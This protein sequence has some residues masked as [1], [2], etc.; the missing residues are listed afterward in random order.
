[1]GKNGMWILL[2][3]WISVL[4]IPRASLAAVT[5]AGNYGRD[6]LYLGD[7]FKQYSPSGH[8]FGIRVGLWFLGLGGEVGVDRVELSERFVTSNIPV[9]LS[10]RVMNWYGGVLI[11][12]FTP[13]SHLRGGITLEKMKGN[14]DGR[15]HGVDN[16]TSRIL[17]RVNGSEIGYYVG[18]GGNYAFGPWQVFTEGNMY[19]PRKMALFQWT[20]GVRYFL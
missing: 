15:P 1:M 5:V 9:E 7:D 20:L 6:T 10:V 18:L 13:F 12:F 8:H 19:K 16:L 2:F 14:I 4:S 11:P 17:E 3:L